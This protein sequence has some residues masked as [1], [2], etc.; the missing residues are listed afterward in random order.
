MDACDSAA[1]GSVSAVRK[2]HSA[3]RSASDVINFGKAVCNSFVEKFTPHDFLSV[4]K[5]AVVESEIWTASV[6]LLKFEILTD[7]FLYC[8]HIPAGY[9][10]S[11]CSSKSCDC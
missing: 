10:Y 2:C 11:I 4:H 1:L 9:L 6:Q 8:L 7:V 3:Y 5:T